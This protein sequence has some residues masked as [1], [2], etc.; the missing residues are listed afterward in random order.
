MNKIIL[1][2]GMLFIALICD[3]GIMVKYIVY[4]VC[5]INLTITSNKHTFYK[6]SYNKGVLSQIP[7]FS[8]YYIEKIGNVFQQRIV[9]NQFSLEFLS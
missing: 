7:K 8:Y 3:I 4:G 1:S 6:V 9:Q 5:C 2:T